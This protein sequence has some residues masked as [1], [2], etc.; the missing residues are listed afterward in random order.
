MVTKYPVNTER[1]TKNSIEVLEQQTL[2]S[3]IKVDYI[4]PQDYCFVPNITRYF[5]DWIIC[6]YR[7]KEIAQLA[8]KID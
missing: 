7:A 1:L 3:C 2:E 6:A 5:L 4:C 8:K